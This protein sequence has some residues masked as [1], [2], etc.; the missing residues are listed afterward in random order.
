MM[1]PIRSLLSNADSCKYYHGAYG[2]T[3]KLA[4]ASTQLEKMTTSHSQIDMNMTLEEVDSCLQLVSAASEQDKTLDEYGEQAMCCMY[5]AL[6]KFRQS[7]TRYFNHIEER[8]KK[9]QQYVTSRDDH[10][11]SPSVRQSLTTNMLDMREPIAGILSCLSSCKDVLLLILRVLKKKSWRGKTKQSPSPG[12][13][14][15]NYIDIMVLLA[16]M[17]FQLEDEDSYYA[18]YEDLATAEQACEEFGYSAGYRWVSGAFYILGAAMAN[19]SMYASAIYPLR[20]ACTLLE[21]SSSYATSETGR[22]HL[23]KRYEI[24]GT[25]CR[26]DNRFEDS[27]KAYR[28]S[29][30]KLPD[31][32][33]RSFVQEADKLAI[34]SLIERN[35]LIPK[36]ID[37]YMRAA[38]LDGVS[39]E[40]TYA[41]DIM[42]LSTLVAEQRCIIYECEL[43]TL[44]TCS[45]QT[46]CSKYQTELIEKL[47]KYYTP[48]LFPIRRA[49]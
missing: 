40:L 15:R 41:S 45:F 11:T 4:L 9:I 25:C 20:K 39:A 2:A 42:N 46:D 10:A 18:S 47:M 23:A 32:S 3:A 1:R 28:S 8:S 29:L 33:I 35:P 7:C 13:V 30:K 31:S 14:M 17:R 21:K 38:L 48:S 5:K 12:D 37:R 6:D 26:K 34:H 44:Y 16:R 27:I 49:R 19:A 43:R 22:L 36:L 24:L